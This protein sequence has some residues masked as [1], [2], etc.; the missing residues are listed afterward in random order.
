M[1]GKLVAPA[2]LPVSEL[3]DRFESA[4]VALRTLRLAVPEL[5]ESAGDTRRAGQEHQAWKGVERAAIKRGLVDSSTSSN[6]AS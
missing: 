4:T 3:R 2:A 1:Y 5:Y 6:T